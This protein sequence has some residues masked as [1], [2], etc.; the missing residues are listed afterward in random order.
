M[1]RIFLLS[2]KVWVKC[3]LLAVL[4]CFSAA[5]NAQAALINPGF[6]M[7]DLT[8][9]STSLSGGSATVVTSNS[10][11]YFL[12]ATYLPPEGS[13]FL[14]VES[15]DADVWQTVSQSLSVVVGETIGGVAAFDWGDYLPYE[16]GV[17]V[18]IL[19]AGGT[20]VAVPFYMDGLLAPGTQ[21]GFGQPDSGY[22]GPWTPW[23]WTATSD[24]VY[25]V[26]Y[27]ARNTLDSGGP[28]QTF[29]YFDAAQV[30]PIPEPSTLLIL[31]F[32]L[33]GLGLYARK[34]IKK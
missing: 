24:G 34:R 14:A 21:K 27:A 10:T 29:G 18:R 33:A 20:E 25:T 3:C 5:V 1:K 16:D 8:G 23:M 7:G 22:N 32:G 4:V 15:G 6:E 26:E 19:D 9:W 2:M 11:D 12:P 17:R 28:N 13:Y 30:S 31:G